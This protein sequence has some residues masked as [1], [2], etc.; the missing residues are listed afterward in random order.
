[1]ID[2]EPS[3]SDPH[4]KM[5]GTREIPENGRESPEALSAPSRACN[6]GRIA[7]PVDRPGDFFVGASDSHGASVVLKEM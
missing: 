4:R 2:G 1:M 3:P 6:I 5:R 7:G